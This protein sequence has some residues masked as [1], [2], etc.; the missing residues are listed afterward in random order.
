LLKQTYDANAFLSVIHKEDIRKWDL[1]KKK[2][3]SKDKAKSLSE[4]LRNQNY[5]ITPLN[6]SSHNGK[7]VY[8]PSQPQ[9]HFALR[10]VDR[11]LRRIYK[12]VQSDR[13]K[14]VRQ[15]SVILEDGGKFALIRS[16]IKSFYETIDFSKSIEKIKQ[17]MIISPAGLSMLES[18]KDEYQR[19]STSTKGIPRG[20]GLSATLSELYLRD[21]DKIFAACNDVIFYSR[22]VD[23]IFIIVDQGKSD[24]I[25]S[26]LTEKVSEIGL[27]LHPAP[28]QLIFETDKPCAFSYLGYLFEIRNI[29]VIKNGKK[30]DTKRVVEVKISPEKVKKIKQR[31]YN[32]LLGFKKDNNFQLLLSRLRYLSCS[33]TIKKNDN[34]NLYA[35]N[36]YNYRYVSNPGCFKVFDA[37]LLNKIGSFAFSALEQQKL[38]RISFYRAFKNKHVASYTRRQISTIKEVWNYER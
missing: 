8:F 37:F 1:W 32:A 5:R 9:D 4:E 29:D 11:Y 17:D 15:I 14:I 30:T 3:E 10:L 34:G 16:D 27:S 28:K 24:K 35:G 26:L 18:L 13:A 22:Y 20:I 12:V 21:L 38:K 31:I 33:K 2:D 19:S 36:A 7:V 23:D 6:K 25:K